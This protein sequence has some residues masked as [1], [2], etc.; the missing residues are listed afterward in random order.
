MHKIVMVGYQLRPC[1]LDAVRRVNEAL[2]DVLNFK[3][4]NTYDVDS[5]L[6]DTRKFV[7][8]LR[9]SKVVLLDVRGG[10]YVSKIICEELNTLK[11]T[12]IVFVGALLR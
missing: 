6:I 5:G 2:G 7:E 3:F 11:N 8:D 4:Y 12:V 10:D 1:L 9:S